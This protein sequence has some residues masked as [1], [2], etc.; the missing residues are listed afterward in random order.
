MSGFRLVYQV[1]YMRKKI[2][3]CSIKSNL[4]KQRLIQ[5]WR[6]ANRLR[7]R[8]PKEWIGCPEAVVVA[9]GGGNAE[10]RSAKLFPHNSSRLTCTVIKGNLN[11]AA[12]RHK[13]QYG[14]LYCAIWWEYPILR[15]LIPRSEN[16]SPRPAYTSYAVGHEFD[17]PYRVITL[18]HSWQKVKDVTHNLEGFSYSGRV[19]VRN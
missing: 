5:E 4:R 10:A 11:A 8:E 2:L 13:T 16:H 18:M 3:V 12:Y 17:F 7:S 19:R 9:P 15:D 14:G 6:Y 1:L